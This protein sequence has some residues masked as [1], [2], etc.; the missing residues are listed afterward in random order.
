M[1]I[2]LFGIVKEVRPE[3]SSNAEV[4]MEE[5]SFEMTSSPDKSFAHV[6]IHV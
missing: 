2:T 5:I 3:Q 1:E 4:P 6:C